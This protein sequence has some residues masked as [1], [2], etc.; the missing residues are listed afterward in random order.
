[1]PRPKGWEMAY[2]YYP[3]NEQLKL[4]SCFLGLPQ[5][6]AMN[7]GGLKQVILTTQEARGLKSK[8]W[9]RWFFLELLRETSSPVLASGGCPPSTVPSRCMNPTSALLCMASPCVSL[10]LHVSVQMSSSVRTPVTLLRAHH[11]P[12]RLILTTFVK[13]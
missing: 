4:S 7:L 3:A 5:Q 2:A 1:M 10:L 9:Q 11:N 13:P 6:T 12:V 8:C